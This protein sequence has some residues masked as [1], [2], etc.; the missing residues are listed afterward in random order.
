MSRGARW[1]LG[2]ALGVIAVGVLVLVAVLL[3]AAS[4]P[5]TA[6]RQAL[7]AST[8]RA[9]D[10]PFLSACSGSVELE[11]RVADPAGSGGSPYRVRVDG[12]GCWTAELSGPQGGESRMPERERGCVSRYDELA[13]RWPG[14]LLHL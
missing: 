12:D 3:R 10:A 1:A 11:C 9:F 2:G 4:T 6:T 8:A 13:A 7:E 14:V 5:G